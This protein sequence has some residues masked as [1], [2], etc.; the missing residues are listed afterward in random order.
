MKHFAYIV[1]NADCS[2]FGFPVDE[3]ITDRFIDLNPEFRIKQ[4]NVWVIVTRGRGRFGIVKVLMDIIEF[5]LLTKRCLVDNCSTFIIDLEKHPE[6]KP[7]IDKYLRMGIMKIIVPG[8]S[9][10]PY[11]FTIGLVRN[12]NNLWVL[13]DLFPNK[14]WDWKSI[15]LNP[16]TTIEN[17]R[18]EIH[19]DVFSMNP[20]IN[21]EILR[22]T[23]YPWNFRFFNVGNPNTNPDLWKEEI[24]NLFVEGRLFA[25]PNWYDYDWI[26]IASSNPAIRFKDIKEIIPHL[27]EK[28]IIGT[29]KHYEGSN[30]PKRIVRKFIKKYFKQNPNSTLEEL[31]DPEVKLYVVRENSEVDMASGSAFGYNFLIDW[32]SWY[33][34][35]MDDFIKKKGED[36]LEWKNF[37][38]RNHLQ[39]NIG[40]FEGNID[41]KLFKLMMDL[42]QDEDEKFWNTSFNFRTTVGYGIL[43]KCKF[44]ME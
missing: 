35:Y 6:D 23:N 5:A 40:I 4:K 7:L 24:M 41:I 17:I 42:F 15:A 28:R 2:L 43:R 19:W 14:P 9:Y 18:P 21:S 22:K 33:S 44:F 27:V 26:K 3:K 16:N 39:F 32:Y 36:P 10:K 38:N 8:T 13:I 25:T 11:I 29:G 20:N 1:L 34:R 12:V 31:N 30:S 37:F